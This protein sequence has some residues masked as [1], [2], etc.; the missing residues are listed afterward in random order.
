[1][2]TYRQTV[3]NPQYSRAISMILCR[4]SKLRV[5]PHV[6]RMI[7]WGATNRDDSLPVSSPSLV[8]LHSHGPSTFTLALPTSYSHIQS[9]LE[10]T[11]T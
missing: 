7:K 9:L 10:H 5:V 3:W 4:P 8:L 2:K 6:L 11:L 1:M